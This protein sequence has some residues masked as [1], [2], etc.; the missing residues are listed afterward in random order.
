MYGTASAPGAE[1]LLAQHGVTF[2]DYRRQDFGA[3]LRERE[4]GGVQGAFD[5]IGGAGLGKAYR[6]LSPGEYWS[7]TPSRAARDAW[8]ATPCAV[9]HV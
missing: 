5:H 9:R 8:S 1:D 3:V 7:A 2:I 6:V 4:P